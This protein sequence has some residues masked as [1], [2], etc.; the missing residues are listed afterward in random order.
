MAT[1]VRLADGEVTA[2]Q[3]APHFAQSGG[4]TQPVSESLLVRRIGD[5][6]CERAGNQLPPVESAF[7]HG[8][9]FN[10]AGKPRKRARTTDVRSVACCADAG[11][12]GLPPP[13]AR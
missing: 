13:E 8:R 4:T 11:P 10:A 3:A 9:S 5:V 6:S 12:W 1:C 2:T 7:A